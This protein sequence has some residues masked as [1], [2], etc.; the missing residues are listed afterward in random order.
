MV[1]RSLS[2]CERKHWLQKQR[3]PIQNTLNLNNKSQEYS[4]DSLRETVKYDNN[5]ALIWKEPFTVT[6]NT[7]ECP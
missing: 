6:E 7:L 5:R 2:F 1:I 4:R 3:D